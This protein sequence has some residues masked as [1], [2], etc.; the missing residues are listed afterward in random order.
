M[1]SDDLLNLKTTHKKI[2][3]DIKRSLGHKVDDNDEESDVET[4]DKASKVM[5]TNDK[6]RTSTE[7]NNTSTT[8]SASKRTLTSTI[9]KA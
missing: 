6:K 4:V 1:F 8:D 5:G 7:A 3:N 2:F 9:D